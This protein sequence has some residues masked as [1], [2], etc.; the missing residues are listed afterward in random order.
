[1]ASPSSTSTDGPPNIF[2]AG[3]RAARLRRA[4]SSF[5]S[6]DFLHRR[7]AE[8]AVNSL[9]VI[10]RE[11]KAPVDLSPHT[12]IF[13]EVLADSP[14]QARVAQIATPSSIEERAAPGANFLPIEEGQVDL[15][16][17]L[18][19]LHWANDLPGAL[20]QIRRALKPDGLFFGSLFGAATLKELRASLTQAELEINGGAQARVSPFADGYDG[21][22]L[23]QR[24]GFALPVTDVD[25][26][27]V[28]YGN[29]LNL[30][31]DLRAMGETNVLAGPIRPLSRQVLGRALELYVQN[32]AEPDGRLPATF[33]MVHLAGWAPH[34]SQQ[35]PSKR[36]SAKASLAEAL[37]PRGNG[38]G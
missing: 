5:A 2:D 15:V 35:K 19:G 12:G 14:A 1:M 27:T 25:R 24:A 34:E 22:G 13:A 8:N 16:V 17:N 7:A 11:F 9:E 21:A 37:H 18:L 10:L 4:Q 20:T 38:A 31:R 3:R 30:M 33:E 6:A 26:F 29:P 32:H 23:L 28:R 36:G